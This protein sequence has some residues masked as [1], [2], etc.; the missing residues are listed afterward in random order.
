M[1]VSKKVMRFMNQDEIRRLIEASRDSYI[2]PLIITAL[3]TGMRKSEL[4]NLMWSD[5]NF[6]QQ[7]ITVQSKGDWHTKN[8]KSRS[9]QLTPV[10]YEVLKAHRQLHLEFRIQNDY[11]LNATFKKME[12]I[13]YK[14]C[15]PNIKNLPVHLLV[16]WR[17]W[18]H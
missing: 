12:Q 2:Y 14:T 15:L 7:M 8:Y 13:G 3:H 16:L 18:Q 5:V 4:F 1:K 11:V 17:Y 9:L 10:L 6:D